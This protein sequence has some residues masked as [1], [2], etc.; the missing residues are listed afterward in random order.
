[1]TIRKAYHTETIHEKRFPANTI[2]LTLD[3]KTKLLCWKF[4]HSRKQ[5][6][7]LYVWL[8]IEKKW[9]ITYARNRYTEIIWDYYRE[10]QKK[11]DSKH[12]NY[13]NM[14][15]HDRKHKSGGGGSRICNNSI[16]DYECTKNPLH[17]F[18][19]CYN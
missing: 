19:R 18:E 11:K 15:K 5:K 6:L 17:D 12:I 10:H 1:M 7:E 4:N 2:V 9:V 16:T 8:P 14:M 13:A 3:N